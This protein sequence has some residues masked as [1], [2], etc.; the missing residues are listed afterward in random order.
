MAP[1]QLKPL[2]LCHWLVRDGPPV[3]SSTVG[4][5]RI[6]LHPPYVHMQSSN[7]ENECFQSEL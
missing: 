5:C 6:R 1:E 7:G 3:W 4:P 2:R